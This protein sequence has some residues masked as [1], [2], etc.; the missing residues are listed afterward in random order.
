[1]ETLLKALGRHSSS[2]VVGLCHCVCIVQECNS[3]VRPVHNQSLCNVAC[4]LVRDYLELE[5]KET[6][7]PFPFD[8]ER[9]VDDFVLFCMLIGNDFLPRELLC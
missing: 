4:R 9:I 1:M 6:A 5:F 2:C 7:L 3:H 8:V